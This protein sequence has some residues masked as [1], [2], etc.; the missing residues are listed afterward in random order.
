MN[1]IFNPLRQYFRRPSIYLKLPS[2]GEFWPEGS[3]ESTENGELP[4]FPMTAIDEITYRTPDALFNG[5]A[6]VSVI[7]SCIPSVKNAWDAPVSDV[8]PILVA[9]RIASYG[10]ELELGTTCPA[11]T[12]EADY[13][14]DLRIVLDQL[15]NPDFK[16]TIKHGDLEISFRPISYRQQHETNNT[17]FEEQRTIQL[18]PGSD[19]PDEEKVKRLNSAL[20]RITELTVMA[21]KHSIAG[22]RT[23]QNI[24][25]EPEFIEEFLN[26]CDRKLFNIIRDRVIELRQSSEL[27]PLH[28]ACTECS[29]EYDQPLTL[30]MASFFE[31]AS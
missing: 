20:K 31:P 6:V 9:I 18:I 22:I 30:D 11:C 25:T 2:K 12:H 19:L 4:V 28:I 16:N 3:L 17:Q 7:Q 26:N 24:V 14:L 8:N 23:P 10:H 5:E 15:K 1:Q 13:T 27:K 21:L 29:H